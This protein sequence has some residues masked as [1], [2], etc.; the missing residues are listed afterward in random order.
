MSNDER[1]NYYEPPKKKVRYNKV[2]MD[3]SNSVDLKRTKNETDRY[4]FEEVDL[5]PRFQE[6]NSEPRF[7]KIDSKPKFQ[8]IEEPRFQ[9]LNSDR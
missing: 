8:E 7:Q 9:E 2:S 5:E 1:L 6:V 4:K 3:C